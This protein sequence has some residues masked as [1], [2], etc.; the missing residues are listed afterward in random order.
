[1]DAGTALVTGA[2][3]GIGLHLAHELARNGHA[4][5]LVAPIED[6]LRNVAASIEREFPAGVRYVA[7]DLEREDALERIARAIG[8]GPIDVLVNN[9]GRGQ[10]GRYWEVPI[11]TQVATLRLN[12][13]AVLRLTA[14]FL[15]GMIERGHG[16]LLNIASITAYEPGPLM[17]VYHA[18]KAF[19]LSWSEALATELDGTGVTCTAVC[20]GP[21]DTDFFEKAG[22]ENSRAF[23]QS[24]L[25]SPQEV[26]ASA[27]AAMMAGTRVAITGALNSAM[28]TASA[29]L[30]ESLQARKNKTMYEDVPPGDRTRSRGDVEGVRPAQ[31]P[32]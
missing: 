29:L 14:H 13:E 15:P 19:L 16:R 12:V 9:A 30:P 4:L 8:D 6:E 3:S 21:T 10:R 32:H 20:P 27:Y 5:V 24:E 28:V 2:T 31:G 1:M 11:E 25:M 7:C 26:A 18:T 22:M 17:S 23:Q